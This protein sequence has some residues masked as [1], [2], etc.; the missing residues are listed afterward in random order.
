MT[1][2]APLLTYFQADP[3]RMNFLVVSSIVPIILVEGLVILVSE[4]VINLVEF[5][6][7]KLLLQFVVDIELFRYYA[8]IM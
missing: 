7:C 8:I 3:L 5:L 1:L 2:M 6:V 4:T